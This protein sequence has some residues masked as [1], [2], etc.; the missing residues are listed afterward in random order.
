MILLSLF[1]L[2]WANNSCVWENHDR[3]NEHKKYTEE[4]IL[5]TSVKIPIKKN[6]IQLIFRFGQHRNQSSEEA[7]PHYSCESPKHLWPQRLKVYSDLYGPDGLLQRVEELK[8]EAVLLGGPFDQ[9]ARVE[10]DR[11]HPLAVFVGFVDE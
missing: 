10:Q 11:S 2:K 3:K 7:T 4:Q 8:A 5:D 1:F 6:V 9:L